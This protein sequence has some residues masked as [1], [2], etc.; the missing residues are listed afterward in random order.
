[1]SLDDPVIITC[2]ISGAIAGRDQC[3]AIPY[4]PEEYG[5][6]AQRIA[7]EGGVMIH[8]HARSPDGAPSHEVEDFRA[9]ADTILAEAGDVILN[10]STGALGVSVD[11]RVAYLRACRPEVA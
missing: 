4:T 1:M 11:K 8:I 3:P 5:A 10:F 9:I 6:E 7:D 2:A